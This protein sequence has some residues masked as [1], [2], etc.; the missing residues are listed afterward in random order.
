MPRKK[1]TDSVAVHWGCIAVVALPAVVALVFTGPSPLAWGFRIGVLG[2]LA[3]L[4]AFGR[5][6]GEKRVAEVALPGFA[7]SAALASCSAPAAYEMPDALVQ[8][9]VL[10]ANPTRGELAPYEAN[11]ALDG[12]LEQLDVGAELLQG[13]RDGDPHAQAVSIFQCGTCQ[14]LYVAVSFT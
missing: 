6:P 9:F 11:D 3:G 2:A 7:L 5:R 13:V 10:L 1:T 12:G 8:A 4:I 14:R